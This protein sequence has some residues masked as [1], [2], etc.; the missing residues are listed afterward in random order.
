VG[1]AASVGLVVYFSGAVVTIVRARAFSHVA[2]PLLY[3]A[4]ALGAGVLVAGG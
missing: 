1:V 2:F 4:P 3:L